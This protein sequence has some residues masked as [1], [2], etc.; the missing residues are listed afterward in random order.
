MRAS[1]C[2]PASAGSTSRLPYPGRAE[3]GIPDR[4]IPTTRPW[5]TSRLMRTAS[6]TYKAVDGRKGEPGGDITVHAREVRRVR[7][8][9]G[10]GGGG[11]PRPR[12]ILNGG[13]GQQGEAG[14]LKAYVPGEGQ[15]KKYGSLPLRHGRSGRG[16][17]QGR[18][19]S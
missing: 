7:V 9:G 2:S 6:P 13:K 5:P 4:G 10:P 8:S 19:Q 17:L 11:E 18:V 12:F 1:W 16:R 3:V 14:G 15:P